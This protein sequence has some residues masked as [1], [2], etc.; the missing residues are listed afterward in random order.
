MEK[1]M[2]KILLIGS[3]AAGKVYIRKWS[4]LPWFRNTEL[5]VANRSIEK[6]QSLLETSPTPFTISQIDADN[7]EATIKLLQKESPDIVVNLALPYQDLSIMEACLATNTHYLDTAN[8]EPPNEA[9]FSYTWQWDYQEKFQ[10]KGIMAIL[11][12]GFDPGVTNIFT[13]FAQKHHF[14]A[15]NELDILDC[16]AGDHGH[17]FAT[18]FNPEINIR[19]I[20]QKGKYFKDGKWIETEPLKEA[21]QFDFPE[22]GKRDAYLMYH[23]ELESITKN[24]PTLRQ[25]RFWMTFSEAYLTHLRVL[26]NIGMTQ[27]T[28]IQHEGQSIIPIKFLKSLLPD[29]SSL[30][31]NYTGKTCIGCLIKGEKDGKEKKLFIYNVSQH[32]ECYKELGSQAISYTTGVPALLGTKLLLEG[33]WTGKGVYNVEEFDPDPFMNEIGAFG[34]PWK[35]QEK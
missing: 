2:K 8:Y 17:P 10:Q 32:E 23:E 18:N 34:L 27:I 9:K 16:N 3:G 35:I 4:T 5:H 14:D 26:E 28:P 21:W 22:I 6:C 7:T 25:A 30:A 12:C 33:K 15:I 20:T 19:E 24:F 29:P 1:K 31:K 13:A 11:G